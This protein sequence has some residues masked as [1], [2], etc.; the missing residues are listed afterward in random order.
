MGSHKTVCVNKT[1]RSS[2]IWVLFT[3]TPNPSISAT[4]PLPTLARRLDLLYSASLPTPAPHRGTLD[5]DVKSTSRSVDQYRPDDKGRAGAGASQDDGLPACPCPIETRADAAR[6]SSPRSSA[7]HPP[8]AWCPAQDA[9]N[10][11]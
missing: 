6:Q 11:Y 10:T 4:I 7:S 1:V 3:R 2:L 8:Y 9:L 5:Q